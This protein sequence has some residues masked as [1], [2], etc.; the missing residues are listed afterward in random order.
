MKLPMILPHEMLD[1]LHRN[2]RIAVS[3]ADIQS[4]WETYKKFKSADHPCCKNM[5]HSPLGIAGDDCKYTLAGAK[6]IIIGFNI[7]LHDRGLKQENYASLP[8]H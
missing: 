4:Y 1:Y 8:R 7:I 2:K 5:R 3:Q 6:V